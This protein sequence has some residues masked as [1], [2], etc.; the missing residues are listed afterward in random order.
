MRSA[1]D[2]KAVVVSV[3]TLGCR[4][5]PSIELAK[6]NRWYLQG[7]RDLKPS[8]SLAVYG[9]NKPIQ[10]Q[11]SV[12]ICA[13]K[14]GRPNHMCDRTRQTPIEQGI[15]THHKVLAYDNV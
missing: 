13:S 6:S 12:L 3:S 7:P 2:Y 10:S 9:I 8:C 4:I 15:S 11:L 1:T 5:D 14:A